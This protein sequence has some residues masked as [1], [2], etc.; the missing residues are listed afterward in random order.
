MYGLS[1][2]NLI[3]LFIDYQSLTSM[4]VWNFIVTSR[5]RVANISVWRNPPTSILSNLHLHFWDERRNRSSLV[6]SWSLSGDR[7][8]LPQPHHPRPQRRWRP[9]YFLFLW[10][11]N[12]RAGLRQVLPTN[13]MQ[14]IPARTTGP[15][16]LKLTLWISICKIMSRVQPVKVFRRLLRRL[17]TLT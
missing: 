14:R 16:I 13:L 9:D 5:Q 15:G 7:E 1:L 12:S 17:T 10:K 3:Y 6:T 11:T 4:T 2:I 8:E